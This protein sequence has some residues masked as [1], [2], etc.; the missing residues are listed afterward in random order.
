MQTLILNLISAAAI[1]VVFIAARY[2]YKHPE[3]LIAE[4]PNED[5]S[6]LTKM[7]SDYWDMAERINEAKTNTELEAWYWEVEQFEDSYRN[8]IEANILRER[9]QGLYD[10]ITTRRDQLAGVFA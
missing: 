7:V 5:D 3:W 4:E 2:L 1:A 6:M 10:R 8:L 9:V